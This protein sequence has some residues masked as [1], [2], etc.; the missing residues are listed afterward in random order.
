MPFPKV[1]MHA[2]LACWSCSCHECAWL[3]QCVLFSQESGCCLVA[4][5]L[6]A[7][8]VRKSRRRQLTVRLLSEPRL[9]H[10]NT[11][12][13]YAERLLACAA[14]DYADQQ[15]HTDLQLG[16]HVQ[17][18][19]LPLGVHSCRASSSKFPLR[20]WFS[21]LVR[22]GQWQIDQRHRG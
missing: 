14:Q 13:N 5:W 11:Q 21:A 10:H 1:L 2:M 19:V 16:Q 8:T 3:I 15:E 6:D 7:V 18:E 9:L 22:S 4:R 12:A 20:R 17:V